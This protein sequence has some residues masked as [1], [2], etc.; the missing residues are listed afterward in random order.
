MANQFDYDAPQVA[1]VA[2]KLAEKDSV[3]SALVSQNYRDEFLAEG[4]ANRPIKVKF[5]TT[6]IA[7]ERA[8]DDVT[9]SIILDEIAESSTTITL[10]KAMDYSAVG[11]SEADLNLK[12]TDFAGQVLRP[13]TA[14]IVDSIEHKLST[15]LLAVPE[16]DL[17]VFDP[18]N[19]V[20]YFTRIRKHLRDN[21]V[22][23]AGIQVAVGTEVYAA[24]L[25]AKAITDV[26]ESGS[27]EALRE[28]GVG[29]L[30]GFTLVESTRIDADEILA[31]H[32]DAVTLVTRAPAVPAGAS[33]GA[34]VSDSGYSLRYLR[35]YDAMKTQDRSI[36]ATFSGVGI[37]PTFKI[38]RNYE[39]R[40]V[41]KTELP[42]GGVLHL[43]TAGA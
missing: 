25:D 10:S 6:L 14:A 18:A 35:D 17:G 20:P 1:I 21:G 28:G 34:S 36:V 11:L 16:T 3:L 39:T 31:F 43:N 9:S 5:P 26:S 33:F 12:L 29:K 24:L 7:R 22:P 40:T 27:T 19:P 23:Q 32:R 37:L 2:A 30:R 8:I 41:V 13:Q 4:T 38:E 15:A 42:Y